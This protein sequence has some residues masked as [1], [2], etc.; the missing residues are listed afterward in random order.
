M[1]KIEY[2]FNTNKYHC[3]ECFEEFKSYIYYKDLKVCPLCHAKIEKESDISINFEKTTNEERNDIFDIIYQSGDVLTWGFDRLAGEL[4]IDWFYQLT[5]NRRKEI[6]NIFSHNKINR[7]CD[8]IDEHWEY[9]KSILWRETFKRLSK[10]KQIDIIEDFFKF[11]E[12]TKD[13]IEDKYDWS[14]FDCILED[15]KE[16]SQLQQI[17]ANWCDLGMQVYDCSTNSD[18]RMCD[19]LRHA[20]DTTA[21]KCFRDYLQKKGLRPDGVVPTSMRYQD[22]Y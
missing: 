10:K 13:I 18:G 14:E 8:F 20:N 12:E 4:L 3:W 2:Y 9:D 11:Y 16:F 6:Y 21:Y 15:K 7:I 17:K 19:C 22:K 1:E 5:S